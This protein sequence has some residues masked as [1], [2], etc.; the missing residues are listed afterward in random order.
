MGTIW[1]PA[2]T[3]VI[4]MIVHLCGTVWWMSRIQAILETLVKQMSSFEVILQ[5]HE[6]TYATKEETFK[7]I[8]HLE[9]Q[10]EA[11]WRRLDNPHACPN[12]KG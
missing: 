1:G 5:K 11:I 6:A 12:H 3:I 10:V 4:F 9:K 2:V 8:A 7:E